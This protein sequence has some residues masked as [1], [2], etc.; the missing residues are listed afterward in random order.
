MR[1][2]I[3]KSG[4]PGVTL[5]AA[6]DTA[7][8][9]AELG[10]RVHA[11]VDGLRSGA[12]RRHNDA[13]V[14]RYEYDIDIAPDEPGLGGEHVSLTEDQLDQGTLELLDE[15]VTRALQAEIARRRE[16]SV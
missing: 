3:V 14:D 1:I 12:A 5:R 4:G 7:E 16:A 2:S 11:M 13:A 9:D 8:L 10:A 6:I 15:L